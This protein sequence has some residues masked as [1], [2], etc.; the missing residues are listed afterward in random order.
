MKQAISGHNSKVLM[1]NYSKTET[2]A[3]TK[4][5]NCQKKAEC[6]LQ[7]KC[8]HDD[9]V[10]YQATVTQENGKVDTYIGVFKF[11]RFG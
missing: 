3:K 4:T 11:L 8:L 1:E 5:C 6:S 10:V 7:N 2:Q 9:G